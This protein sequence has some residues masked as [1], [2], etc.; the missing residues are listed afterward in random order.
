MPP[1]ADTNSPRAPTP[2]FIDLTNADENDPA[3][4][5]SPAPSSQGTITNNATDAAHDSLL[6][7]IEPTAADPQAA[8]PVSPTLPAIT[9]LI[10]PLKPQQP[11]AS[12]SP[13][14]SPKGSPSAPPHQKASNLKPPAASPALPHPTRPKESIRQRRRSQQRQ[15]NRVL[16]NLPLSLAE[17]KSVQRTA[18]RNSAVKKKALG[19]HDL[20]TPLPSP[21]SI[22]RPMT[23]PFPAQQ[24]PQGHQSHCLGSSPLFGEPSAMPTII[25]WSAA[26]GPSPPWQSQPI[27]RL[28]RPHPSGSPP[29]SGERSAMP[30]ITNWSIAT[31]PSPPWQTQPI[32]QPH[33]PHPF[34][35]LP[36]PQHQQ[37]SSPISPATNQTAAGLPNLSQ[38]LPT[39]YHRILPPKYSRELISK[40][41]TYCA[42]AWTH[43]IVAE[44]LRGGGYPQMDAKTVG[45]I[46]NTYHHLSVMTKEGAVPMKVGHLC[47][48]KEVL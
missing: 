33:R 17:Q 29:L 24:L 22:W 37:A 48:R 15:K 6:D 8:L 32:H 46:W 5:E 34:G 4:L 21:L 9:P 1:P 36:L 28:H 11:M 41:L 47:E 40:V 18:T 14:A 7:G 45:Y 38:S 42:F 39:S 12:S 2:T 23:A 19:P 25:N 13:L 27:H 35:G 43:D 3:L 20:Q 31:G 10:S 26:T 44:Y 16:H 30:A